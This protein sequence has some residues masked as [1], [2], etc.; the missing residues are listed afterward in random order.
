MP[1]P[2]AAAATQLR[3][4]EAKTGKKLEA[5][6]RIVAESGLAKVSEQRTMLMERFG[7]GYGDANTVALLAKAAAAPASASDDPLD[8]IYSGAKAHLPGGLKAHPRPNL[9]P[10]IGIAALQGIDQRSRGQEAVADALGGRLRIK[11]EI[12]VAV[13]VESA[14]DSEINRRGK[15]AGNDVTQ[16]GI[17]IFVVENEAAGAQGLAFAPQ[18]VVH[19]GQ[20]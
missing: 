13:P 8:A 20:P 9:R 11:K 4:I 19:G 10:A 12:F 1:D 17:E 5:L 3:N 15:K 7:L 18:V 16:A 6:Y 14:V 2:A